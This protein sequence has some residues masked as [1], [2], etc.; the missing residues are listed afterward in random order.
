MIAS[1]YVSINRLDDLRSDDA[2][3]ADGIGLVRTELLFP[4][5]EDEPSP[6]EQAEVYRQ[7]LE[8]SP[9]ETVV[10]RAFDGGGDKMLKFLGEDE[11]SL[12]I[13]ARGIRR[14]LSNEGVLRRQLAGIAMAA[15]HS[16]KR[17]SVTGPMIN[18]LEEASWFASLVTHVGL[19]PG[20]TVE[21]PAGC[22]SIP[23]ILSCVELV[24][25][26]TN[27]LAQYMFAADRSDESAGDLLDPW[28]PAFVRGMHL[29]ITSAPSDRLS[30]CGMA[31][32]DPIFAATCIG[33]GA[34]TVVVSPGSVVTVKSFLRAHTRSDLARMSCRALAGLN[35]ASS[36][37]AA[38]L[39]DIDFVEYSW[40]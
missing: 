18:T 26:G 30:V 10:F 3:Q 27:D 34:S 12:S 7:I 6:D 17:V 36:R 22:I 16:V 4:D 35:P 11:A 37:L 5:Y 8:Q 29:A 24:S 14:L 40:G 19:V 31:V 20:A 38:V 21:T 9:G 28:Q 25:I 32:D 23:D 1:V 15:K 39:D 2:R 33:S 13:P